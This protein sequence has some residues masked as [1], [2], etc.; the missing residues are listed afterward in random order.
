[1]DE[2]D[3]G[4]DVDSLLILDREFEVDRL[5][6]HSLPSQNRLERTGKNL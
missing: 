3:R 1:V 2:A 6:Q 4:N 5:R